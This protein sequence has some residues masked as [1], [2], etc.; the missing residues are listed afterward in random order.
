M[1]VPGDVASSWVSGYSVARS[2]RPTVAGAETRRSVD[3]LVIGAWATAATGE[4]NLMSRAGRSRR[5]AVLRKLE[6]GG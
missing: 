3:E 2:E 6:A 5:N 1:P 4:T